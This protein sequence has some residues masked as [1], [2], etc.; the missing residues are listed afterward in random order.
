[1][2][3]LSE[4]AASNGSSGFVAKE[5][6]TPHTRNVANLY[7]PN[8]GFRDAMFSAG[9][10]SDVCVLPDGQ[11]HRFKAEGDKNKDSWYVFYGDGG[12]FGNWRTGL[13][14]TWFRGDLVDVRRREISREIL[15]AQKAG[16]EKTRRQH[17]HVAQ[18][19]RHRWDGAAPASTHPYLAAKNVRSHGLRVEGDKLLIP[20]WH[21][22]RLWSL[23]TIVADGNQFKKRFLWHGRKSGCYLPIG[24]PGKRI[25]LA[26]GYSTA[27][28]VHEISGDC[29]VCTFDAHNMAKVAAQ[30]RAQFIHHEIYVAADNDGTGIKAAMDAMQKH[31]LEG[32]I[33]PDIEKADW[34]DYCAI[35]GPDQTLTALGA[36]A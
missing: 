22:R 21:K 8:D 14:E 2:T 27:A 26:E 7:A 33:W 24:V 35:H 5:G 31:A 16:R 1:M 20:M 9:L 25:W 3:Y 13:R 12:A 10:I 28:S 29:V 19:A 6:F 11:I 17:L 18:A 34:N 23:Q 15:A 30:V 32:A 36:V 4:M